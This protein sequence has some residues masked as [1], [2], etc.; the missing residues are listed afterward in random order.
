MIEAIILQIVSMLVTKGI[1]KLT[2]PKVTPQEVEN[3]IAPLKQALTETFDG[4]PVTKEQR[5]KLKQSVKTL[6]KG[7]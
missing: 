3:R 7:S 6:I 4:T 5:K 2:S 1:E